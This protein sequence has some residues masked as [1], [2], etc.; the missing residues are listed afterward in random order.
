MSGIS[1]LALEV[2][3]SGS[4]SRDLLPASAGLTNLLQ[5]L[6]SLEDSHEKIPPTRSAL[7]VCGSIQ[8]PSVLSPEWNRKS[9]SICGSAS[10]IF[11]VLTRNPLKFATTTRRWVLSSPIRTDFLV[12]AELLTAHVTSQCTRSVVTKI[13]CALS[14]SSISLRRLDAIPLACS[15]ISPAIRSIL[16]G[17]RGS[18]PVLRSSAK[19]QSIETDAAP[20]PQGASTKQRCPPAVSNKN[21][22][23]DAPASPF[24]SRMAKSVLAH[25]PSKA[26]AK[27]F[28]VSASPSPPIGASSSRCEPSSRSPS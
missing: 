20:E 18:A 13:A 3:C 26:C 23:E 6:C 2:W 8:M 10:L 24:G 11:P 28:F 17:V 15:D 25:E 7:L 19:A 16:N 5:V 27:C 12:S 14:A 9:S 4:S 22:S 1:N 21:A